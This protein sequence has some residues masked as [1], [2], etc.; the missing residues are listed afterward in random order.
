M[1]YLIKLVLASVLGG[2]YIIPLQAEPVVVIP[3]AGEDVALGIAAF[4]GGN[5]AV[6]LTTTDTVYRSVTI[7]APRA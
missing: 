7:N 6:E 2:M 3:L 4:A 5:Q 1:K